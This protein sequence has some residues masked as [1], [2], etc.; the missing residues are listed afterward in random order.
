MIHQ[1]LDSA[2]RSLLDENAA[3]RVLATDFIFTEGPI[4]HPK[5]QYLLFSD[6]P[7]GIRHCWDGSR[8]SIALTPS[9]M[10]NG[11]TYDHALN[12]LVCEH[13]TSSV[14]RFSG[15]K[16]QVLASHFEGEELNS[17]NDIVTA[18]DGA[19]WFSD[20]TYGRMPVFGK[21]RPCQLD[22]RGVFR[23]PPAGSALELVVNKSMFTQPNGLCFSPNE[24][25]L[26]INDTE[27]ANI[28]VFDVE[29]GKLKNV[30]MF[31]EGIA[32]T[33]QPNRRPDG[34]KCDALGNIWCTGPDGLW[35][36]APDGRLL[37]KVAVPEI[38]ANLH[39][40]GKNWRTLF[41]TASTS[42]YALEIKVGP[43]KESFMSGYI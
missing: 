12:L 14:A 18:A 23:I 24:K 35:V 7:P 16:R 29:A 39:W 4:W 30:R 38:V 34:M 26:Y 8:A 25:L 5:D 33:A 31:A 22:F 36:Y 17:P 42:L 32:D 1:V 9:N 27:Q 15:G 11:M 40:G 43:H 13:A 19:I 20:P 21:E 41:I 3:P 10:G 37:G 2:F 6:I 28:R